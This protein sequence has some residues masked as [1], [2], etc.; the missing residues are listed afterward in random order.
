MTAIYDRFRATATRL[1]NRF[2][3]EATETVV[4]TVT[5]NPDPLLPPIVDE[6]VAPIPAAVRGASASIVAND[7]N[8]SMTDLQVIM[9]YRGGVFDVGSGMHIDGA[10]RVVVRVDRIPASG[11]LCAVRAYVR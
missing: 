6:A 5:P 2:D 4:R 9:D 10:S 1:I 3:Q 7:P 11:L 8:L